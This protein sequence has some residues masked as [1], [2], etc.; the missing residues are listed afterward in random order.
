MFTGPGRYTFTSIYIPDRSIDIPSPIAHRDEGRVQQYTSNGAVY[1]KWIV[2][3][4]TKAGKPTG[5]YRIHSLLGPS[6][7][8]GIEGDSKEDY[9]RIQFQRP[10]ESLFQRWRF[11]EEKGVYRILNEG[12]GLCIDLREQNR[13]AGGDL[14]QRP[15]M[16]MPH[17]F[18]TIDPA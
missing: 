1:Q 10:S 4:D 13:P 5:L 3:E 9:A 6:K 12:S 2:T 14:Q 17:Q 15:R 16:D 18:W 8:L 7:V 11:E